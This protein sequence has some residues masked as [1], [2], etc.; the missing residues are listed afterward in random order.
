[1]W[2]EVETSLAE[3]FRHE[4]K[5][6]SALKIKAKLENP[7]PIVTSKNGTCFIATAA[8]GTP[9]ATEIDILRNWRDEYLEQSY[10][11]RVFVK[12]YYSLSPPVANNISNS[13]VK[14]RIVRTT[15]NPIVKVLAPN[16]SKYS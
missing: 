6:E 14:K 15:L 3:I 12:V 9:F 10:F 4:P 16:Y 5:N 8:Y 2:K 1:M 11:G 13:E 7:L